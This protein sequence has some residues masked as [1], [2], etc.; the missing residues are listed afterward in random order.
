MPG[1]WR[2]SGIEIALVTD[3]A[4]LRRS[5]DDFVRMWERAAG[6]R[7]GPVVPDGDVVTDG[8]VPQPSH[9]GRLAG[10]P[11]ECDVP[12]CPGALAAGERCRFAAECE[13]GT[14]ADAGECGSPL[15]TCE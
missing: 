15:G 14:C 4:P 1:F 7:S 10:F 13:S 11:T 12:Y 6:P 9:N 2:T 5:A 8:V 3:T